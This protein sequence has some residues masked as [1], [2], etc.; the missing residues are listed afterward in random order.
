[1]KASA[2]LANLEAY[3]CWAQTYPPVPHNP[4]MRVEQKAMLESWPD[5]TAARALDLACGSGRYSAV[6]TQR[7]AACVI[8][9]DYSLA[10]LQQARTGTRVRADMMALPFAASAFDVVVCGL[11]VG[12]APQLPAWM[13]EVARV[14]KPGGVL[15]YSD[16]HPDAAA[17]GMERSFTDASQRKHTLLHRQYDLPAHRAAAAAAGLE[18]EVAREARVGVDLCEEF[19]GSQAFYSRWRGLP[20]VLVI[21]ARKLPS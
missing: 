3:E 9:V 18:L 17:A 11:A 1:M 8:G 20:I 4:L 15:L 19:K 12:H 10:M 5:V 16:F 7:G 13:Q 14:M 6:L 21:R 2:A